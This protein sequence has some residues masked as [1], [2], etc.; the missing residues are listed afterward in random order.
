MMTTIMNEKNVIDKQRIQMMKMKCKNYFTKNL[1]MRV[2]LKNEIL[3]YLDKQKNNFKS[4]KN[5]K[6][7]IEKFLNYLKNNIKKIV[8]KEK[9][10]NIIFHQDNMF[11][12]L[13]T[14]YYPKNVVLS[15]SSYFK[16]RVFLQ[17][18]FNKVWSMC[19]FFMYKIQWNIKFCLVYY[20]QVMH[21]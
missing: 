17:F 8:L 18:L 16:Q 10:I 6:R 20:W 4:F 11:W 1:M 9:K 15:I 5:I 21:Q 7:W 13:N 14:V 19:S 3:K 12:F 2:I